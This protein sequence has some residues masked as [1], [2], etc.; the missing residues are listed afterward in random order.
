LIRQETFSTQRF[1]LAATMDTNFQVHRVL[2]AVSPGIMSA[3]LTAQVPR[4]IRS[5]PPPSRI[6]HGRQTI[7]DQMHNY[8]ACDSGKQQIFVLHGLG[9]AGKTQ[10]GLKFIEQSSWQVIL[11]ECC[12]R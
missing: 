4:H 6:F 11:L 5:R 8:F 10:I 12:Y 9:G 3:I 2:D 1:Q 7:L